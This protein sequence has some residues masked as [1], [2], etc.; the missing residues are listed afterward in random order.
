MSENEFMEVHIYTLG[1]GNGWRNLG[2]DN[3]GTG[4][5]WG[6]GIFA[7]GVL[8]WLDYGLERIFPF[9]LAEEKFCEYMSLPLPPDYDS[10]DQYELGVL[11]GYLCFAINLIVNEAECSD[12]RL[13]KKK[14]DNHGTKEGEGHS[15][16]CWS[17]EF[18]IFDSESFALTK[19]CNILTYNGSRININDLEASTSKTLVDFTE[20][21]GGVFPHKN[22]LVSLKEL[23]EEDA[24]IMESVEFEETK[25]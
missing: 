3:F 8:Y 16:M 5:Y 11:N 9:D 20:R 18:R 17:E 2:K 1:N 24:K 25:P 13:L 21:F 22:T 6:E 15:S 12:V 23:G 4:G 19:S 7:S 14:Y 10:E